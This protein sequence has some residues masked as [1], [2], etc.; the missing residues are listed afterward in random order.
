MSTGE[1]IRRLLN[2]I[3]EYNLDAWLGLS[4][5]EYRTRAEDNVTEPSGLVLICDFIE[6]VKTA[7]VAGLPDHTSVGFLE[8]IDTLGRPPEVQ[9]FIE[10]NFRQTI[11]IGTDPLS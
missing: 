1:H 8:M 3:I 11:P 2:V 5:D 10:M 6:R 9:G 7:I 4:T